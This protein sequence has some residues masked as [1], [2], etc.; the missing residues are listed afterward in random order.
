MTLRVY[1]RVYDELGNATWVEIT[2]D[3]NGLNDYVYVTA[4]IQ[5]LKLNLNE[6]PFWGNWGIPAK[7]SVVQQVA[8]DYYTMIMQERFA[9][10]F[11]SL[12]ISRV[13]PDPA[14]PQYKRRTAPTYRVNIITHYGV[15]IEQEVPT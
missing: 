9:P 12:I 4:L 6:S 7:P 13:S 8:P 11:M 14:D 3:P 5:C 2:T 1:G 10:Y 15:Q